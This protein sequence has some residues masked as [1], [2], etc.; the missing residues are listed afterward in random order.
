MKY[1]F[2][3]LTYLFLLLFPTGRILAQAVTAELTYEQLFQALSDT[4]ARHF[5]STEVIDNSFPALTDTYRKQLPAIQDQAA[6]AELANAYLAEFRT[7]HTHYYTRQDAAYY[8]LA[9]LFEYLPV[10][11][12]V[13]PDQEIQYP[14]IGLLTDKTS[15]GV[16]IQGVLDGSSAEQAGL[17]RGDI[18]RQLAGAP[19]ALSTLHQHLDQ[20]IPIEVER[21]GLALTFEVTPSLVHPQREMEAAAQQS[22]RLIDHEEKKLA[23]IHLWS[24][25]GQQYY[26]LLKDAVL[27]GE[28]KEAD[29]LILDV[30]EGW[31]GASPEYLNLFN[32]QVPQLRFSGRGEAV[33]IFDSQWRKPVVLLTNERVRSGKELL[34]YGFKKYHIGAVIGTNTAGAVTAGRIFF[35]PDNSMLYLAV[36]MVTVDGEV[37]E[38][39][40]VK[41]DIRV[42]D[43]PATSMDEQLQGAIE[44]LGKQ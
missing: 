10:V 40:G 4:V 34:A 29:A 9:A 23:Y 42:E 36:S 28:L 26:E 8:Y 35:L 12:K 41:P 44:W 27:Y 37:L 32:Q 5:Y 21:R 17:Q 25:A 2:L 38:G 31:G 18:V 24:F 19:Y 30:R 1:L 22:A 20:A 43:D 15:Q 3:K 11:K 13:F 39:Q 7:S 33:T 16:L 14:S 6:F